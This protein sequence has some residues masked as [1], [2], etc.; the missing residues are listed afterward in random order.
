MDAAVTLGMDTAI[1]PGTI[2]RE[3][4]EFDRVLYQLHPQVG[5]R[6][7]SIQAMAEC[8]HTVCPKH[9]LVPRACRQRVNYCGRHIQSK[10]GYA[11][12]FSAAMPSPPAP[13]LLLPRGPGQTGCPAQDHRRCLYTVACM[14]A[15]GRTLSRGAASVAA[16]ALDHIVT[17]G[18]IA[19]GQGLDPVQQQYKT[20]D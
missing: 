18:G 3:Q 5:E 4:Q 13:A 17:G 14:D 1:H 15:V 7:L 9:R 11:M 12:S 10:A 8:D 16:W 19:P 2:R 6:I 20:Q